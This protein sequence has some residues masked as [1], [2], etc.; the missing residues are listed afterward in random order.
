MTPAGAAEP[1]GS[2]PLL[3]LHAAAGGATGFGHVARGS[4]IGAAGRRRGWRAELLVE[5]PDQAEAEGRIPS[6]ASVVSTRTAALA[7][8]RASAA[9]HQGPVILACDLPDR[10]IADGAHAA[11]DGFDLTVLLNGDPSH[12][13]PADV[14]FLRGR[15]SGRPVQAR[16]VAMGQAFEVVR[17]EVQALRPPQPWD[18][19]SIDRV[20][21]SFGGSD[22]G[23]QTERLAAALAGRRL[24]ETLLVAGPSFG[25]ARVQELCRLAR[26]PM[27]V[28][29]APDSL[30]ALMVD[31]DLVV[32]M[33]GQSVLEALHLG[34]P[35][36]AIR[37]ADLG[38]DVAWLAEE[39]LVH[40]LGPVDGA[41]A[42]LERVL[43]APRQLSELAEAGW[44][45]I[46]G[47]G[48]DR[49]VDVM[50]RSLAGIRFDDPVLAPVERERQTR[51]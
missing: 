18:G 21:V 24:P 39:R 33:G 50:A 34:R 8:R 40:D 16:C 47:G 17:P 32:S 37:W 20:L 1:G 48:A 30:P 27:S 12:P 4:A 41:A 3:V 44:R 51:E 9:A 35:V 25:Q 49:C 2:T 10:R 36:A 11:A 6:D 42:A 26:P 43:E 7:R 29:V 46:D 14:V 38:R 19:S 31:A 45:S 13:A 22:P 28:V 23:R 5:A 15:P